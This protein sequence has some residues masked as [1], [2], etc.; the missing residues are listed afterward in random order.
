MEKRVLKQIAKRW[1]KGV[2]MASE[3][4]CSFETSG[5]SE[6]EMY[7]L[8]SEITAIANR[9]TDKQAAGDTD[10]LVSEYYDFD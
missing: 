1:C 7:F 8:Q 5:L 10:E 4:I 3:A 2:L 6:E 9:I